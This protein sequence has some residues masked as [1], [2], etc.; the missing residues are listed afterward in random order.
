VAR[1]TRDPADAR[2][3]ERQA[4]HTGHVP[5]LTTSNGGPA[6]ATLET[7]AV[8]AMHCLEDA[9]PCL[10]PRAY[11]SLHLVGRASGPNE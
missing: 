6:N 10:G 3:R 2:A 7:L 9:V 4:R 1:L 5:S 11:S 8:A